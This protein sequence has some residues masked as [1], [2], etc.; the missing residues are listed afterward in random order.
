MHIVPDGTNLNDKSREGLIA[1]IRR[2]MEMERRD[3]F[4]EKEN[5][6]AQSAMAKGFQSMKKRM[7]DA[8]DENRQLKGQ[9]ARLAEQNCLKARDAFGRKPEKLA[10]L[11]DSA[12]VAGEVDE[13]GTDGSAEAALGGPM[14]GEASPPENARKPAAPRAGNHGKKAKGK[15][16]KDLSGLDGRPVFELNIEKLD[17][18]YGEGNWRI[19]GWHC[20]KSIVYV[21]AS[22]FVEPRYTP[23]ISIGLEHEMACA[24]AENVLLKNSLAS[25]PLAA[26][27]LYDKFFL[28]IPVYRQ[29]KALADCGIVLSRQTM[30]NWILRFASDVFGPVYDRMV[31]ALMQLPYHQCDETTVCVNRDGR[32]AGRKSYMWLHT[33]SELLC[34]SPVVIFCFELTRGTDHLR[35]FYAGCTVT[36]TCDAYASYQTL[37]SENP[38]AVTISGC[39]MHMRRR[40]ADALALADARSMPGE[41]AAAL[42]EAKALEIIGRVYHEEGQLKS[43][44]AETRK[45]MRREKIAPLLDEYYTYI[46][47]IDLSGPLVSGRLKDAVGYSIN[48]RE[49]LCRFLHDGNIPIDNGAAERHIRQFAIGRNNWLFCDSIDGARAT[50][51]MYSIIETARANGA[52]VYYYLLYLLEEVPKHLSGTDRSFLDGMMP[53][54]EEY[55]GYEKKRIK[56]TGIEY[57]E[58]EYASPPKAPGKSR[59]RV[60]ASGPE[61]D[62]CTA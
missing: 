5:S 49:C 23:V 14:E 40:Y 15:R 12:P 20:H 35:D 11:L 2:Y 24:E 17:A 30:C 18:A 50:A 59:K 32:K 10:G 48:Q 41:K 26:K 21:P 28:A 3:E 22:A 52:N 46:Q 37:A 55:R 42:P 56:K 1:I 13:A 16:A 53:W 44:D 39:M 51:T 6:R 9:L 43:L 47:S 31:E 62:G 25:P 27:I 36:T 29:E 54:S 45:A 34:A 60:G 61:P 19:A 8:L 4:M 38:G 7:E 57:G 33:G 58:C